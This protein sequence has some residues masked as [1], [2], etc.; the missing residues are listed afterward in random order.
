MLTWFF[1]NENAINNI[2]LI[3]SIPSVIVQ[4]RYDIVCPMDTAWELH[5]AW[6]AEFIVAENSGH[7]AFEKEITHH[8]VNATDKFASQ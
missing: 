6:P 3:R 8:L 2:D 5:Q 1:E 4:G 7:S